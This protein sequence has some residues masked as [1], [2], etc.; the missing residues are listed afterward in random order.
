VLK[1]FFIENEVFSISFLTCN[2]CNGIQNKIN[3]AV[4]GI[5]TV[6]VFLISSCSG[7]KDAK[8]VSQLNKSN[9]YQESVL[10]Y[11]KEDLPKPLHE[12]EIDTVLTKIFSYQSLNAA[13][14]IGLLDYLIRYVNHSKEYQQNPSLEKRISLIELSQKITQRMSISSLEIAAI[15]SEMN[16]EEERAD[17]ISA[18]LKNK[19]DDAATKLTVGAIVVGA[20]SAVAVG[21]ILA[22]GG[23]GNAPEFIGIGAGLTEATLGFMILSNK[24]SVYFYHP[25]NALNDIWT[26]PETSNIFPPSVWYYL[27]YKKPNNNDQSLRQQLVDKWLGLEQIADANEKNK[28]KIYSLFLADGGKYSTEQLSKRANL[29]DQIEA[30]IN[31]MKQDLNQL[32]KEIERILL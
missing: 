32:A 24:R 13:H 2:M 25:R 7:T 10:N 6:L 19:E 17:Q 20:L 15:V 9:C 23:G 27:T 14:A 31:L 28:E 30:Y 18:F 12:L 11:T 22:N 16:C 4:T 26:G 5:A 3:H 21:I 29:Y 1:Y 8:F